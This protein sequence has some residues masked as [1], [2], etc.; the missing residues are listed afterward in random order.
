VNS[1][2]VTVYVTTGNRV[3]ALA[4]AR[5]VVTEKLAACANILGEVTS[6]Y[7]WQGEVHEDAEVALVLKSRTELFDDLCARIRDLHG[8]DCP[9]IVAWPIEAGSQDYLSWIVDQTRK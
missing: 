8:Y 9:C 6:V 5:T 3:E 7:E 2:F 1:A 4:I